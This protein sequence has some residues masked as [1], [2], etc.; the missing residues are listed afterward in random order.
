MSSG[1]DQPH[2]QPLLLN[3]GQLHSVGGRFHVFALF[4]LA[5]AHIPTSSGKGRSTLITMARLERDYENIT[6]VRRLDA[7]NLCYVSL[8]KWVL[9]RGLHT[10]IPFRRTLHS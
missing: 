7:S 2:N 1:I 9:H 4:Y 10:A 8:W 3:L 5:Y 6:T